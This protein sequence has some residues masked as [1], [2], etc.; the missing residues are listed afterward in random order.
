MV[1]D[2]EALPFERRNILRVIFKNE[3]LRRD[4]PKRD[5]YARFCVAAFRTQT[6]KAGAR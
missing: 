5:A 4:M 2:Y 3:H 6:V 1:G